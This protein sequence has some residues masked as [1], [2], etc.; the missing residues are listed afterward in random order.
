MNQSRFGH[1]VALFALFMFGLLPYVSTIKWPPVASFWAEWSAA[2]LAAGVAILVAPCQQ[3]FAKPVA[4]PLTALACITGALLITVQFATHQ[5]HFRGAALLAIGAL[6][7]AAVLCTS[8]T[9]LLHNK[10]YSAELDAWAMGFIFA[11]LLNCAEVLAE[12]NGWQIYL[13][14]F[15]AREGNGRA[16]GLFGQSNQVAV[17]STM[18]WCGAQYLWMRGK[19]ANLN[20]LGVAV[21]AGCIGAGAGSRAGA[22]LFFAA[23]AL[24]WC[25]LRVHG[26]RR[27]GQMLLLAALGIFPLM[28]AW[29]ALTDTS[30][31]LAESV[32]RSE[33]SL[34]VELLR[35]GFALARLHPL[36]GVGFGNFSAAR[37]A[38]LSTP[39]GEPLAAHTHNVI[40]QLSAELGVVGALAILLL[41][42]YGVLKGLYRAVFHKVAPEQ[43]FVVGI[44]LV[45]SGYS[46]TEYPLWYTFFLFPFAFAAGLVEQP[47]IVLR[48]MQIENIMTGG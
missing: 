38:E 27:I 22:I 19:L 4:V 36:A 15:V 9:R 30:G 25:A 37:W 18:A 10:S 23:T 3:A 47:M 26:R 35:D 6:V 45:I 48:P 29:W 43:F 40:V 28:H 33:T 11:M 34:R 39:M 46:L 41:A 32:L 17:F 5:P 13:Y 8:A 31:G 14:R 21:A 44:L 12:R 20:L 24:A 16:L 1:R 42:G 7:L 2:V